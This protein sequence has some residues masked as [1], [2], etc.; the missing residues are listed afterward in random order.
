MVDRRTDG[1]RSSPV[2]RGRRKESSLASVNEKRVLGFDRIRFSPR[3]E[4]VGRP[5]DRRFPPHVFPVYTATAGYTF[6]DV[7]SLFST[8]P[9]SNS[10][11]CVSREKRFSSRD[12]RN[13]SER[14]QTL[15]PH[16][17]PSVGTTKCPTAAPRLAHTCR[18]SPPV[19]LRPRADR[20]ERHDRLTDSSYTPRY[21]LGAFVFARRDGRSR[22]SSSSN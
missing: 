14:S 11:R 19:V 21:T 4:P 22:L 8:G 13:R 6:F 20:R 3:I 12:G 15:T 2:S 17:P 10:D 9:G 18:R 1:Q 5:E 16:P 7:P